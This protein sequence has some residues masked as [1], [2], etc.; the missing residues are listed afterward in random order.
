MVD[1]LALTNPYHNSK[2]IILKWM[3][4]LIFKPYLL[5]GFKYIYI[6]IYIENHKY[7]IQKNHFLF[8]MFKT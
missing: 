4:R 5:R 3:Y 1:F 6:Y 7:G 8:S 2:H